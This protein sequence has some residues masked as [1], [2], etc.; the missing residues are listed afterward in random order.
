MILYPAN[1][2]MEEI[3][4]HPALSSLCR[5]ARGGITDAIAMGSMAKL[6]CF[7]ALFRGLFAAV[8]WNPVLKLRAMLIVVVVVVQ[9]LSK[10]RG[11]YRNIHLLCIIASAASRIGQRV[12]DQSGA[13]CQ[14]SANVPRF[15]PKNEETTEGYRE[16]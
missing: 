3:R 14:T 16:L 15:F 8:G 4:Y 1:I 2:R 12:R 6:M 10:S 13:G 5:S 9:E 7:F 11:I